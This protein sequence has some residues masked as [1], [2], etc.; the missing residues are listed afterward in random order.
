MR[1]QLI[2]QYGRSRSQVIRVRHISL[3]VVRSYLTS[4]RRIRTTAV[5]TFAGIGHP[6][7]VPSAR[8]VIDVAFGLAT[9]GYHSSIAHVFRSRRGVRSRRSC[10]AT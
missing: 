5:R 9:S 6:S 7:V 3:V 1:T 4:L 8:R 2:S 10:E